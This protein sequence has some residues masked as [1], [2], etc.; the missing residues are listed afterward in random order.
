MHHI[1]GWATAV[2]YVPT[3]QKKHVRVLES[4]LSLRRSVALLPQSGVV[5]GRAG[6]RVSVFL[7]VRASSTPTSN[8]A[9]ESHPTLTVLPQS[10]EKTLPASRASPDKQSTAVMNTSRYMNIRV[11]GGICSA[12][13][14]TFT[15]GNGEGKQQQ[16]QQSEQAKPR[17]RCLD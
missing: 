11:T 1:Q 2:G 6:V 8:R 10:R 13:T 12:D 9:E 17:C 15:W 4:T 5:H 16:Q 14:S 7:L 3:K